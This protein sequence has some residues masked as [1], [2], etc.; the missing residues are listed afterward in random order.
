VCRYGAEGQA[1]LVRYYDTKLFITCLVVNRPGCELTIY[2]NLVSRLRIGGDSPLLPVYASLCG[3]ELL[4]IFYVVHKIIS[5]GRKF[6]RRTAKSAYSEEPEF[7]LASRTNNDSRH[8]FT[9]ALTEDS[10]F[11]VKSRQ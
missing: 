11:D 4:Y 8:Y 6:L 2:L 5:T 9:V 1:P 3:Q 7:R 10:L